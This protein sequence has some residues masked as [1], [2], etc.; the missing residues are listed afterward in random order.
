[1]TTA[2]HAQR[3]IQRMY[4]G[5]KLSRAVF[6]ERP[7]RWH[8]EIRLASGVLIGY[9]F[10]EGEAWREAYAWHKRGTPK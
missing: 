3:F 9:G 8:M 1:M 6:S 4:P 7:R 2:T 10:T 5:A